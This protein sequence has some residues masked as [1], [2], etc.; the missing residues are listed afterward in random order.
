MNR[1]QCPV[2]GS[3]H[4]YTCKE[5]RGL[6]KGWCQCPVS[7]SRHFYTHKETGNKSVWRCQCP[8]SGSR[9]F[10][11][12]N[13][14]V[15]EFLFRCQCPVSGSRHF[16]DI[17]ETVNK[18][19][20]KCQCP[21]SGSRHFYPTPQNCLI[22]CGFPAPFLHIFV[23]I[24]WNI[25]ISVPLT[26]LLTVRPQYSHFVHIQID[27]PI[28]SCKLLFIIARSASFSTMFLRRNKIVSYQ[29]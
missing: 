24:F 15:Y 16:Y 7:G 2:S 8:V 29:N 4:F 19:A 14:N 17:P 3:R 1:C 27:S 26:W 6:W 23:R 28:S 18:V 9:H 20:F 12:D 11:D 25:A 21:V 22:L 5:S 13:A 10:Y